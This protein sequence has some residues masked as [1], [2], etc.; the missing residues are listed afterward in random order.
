MSDQYDSFSKI[1]ED[2]WAWRRQE[3]PDRSLDEPLEPRLPD[4]GPERQEY[5]AVR[6]RE[7]DDQLEKIDR[8]RLT[9][10]QAEDF[11]VYRFQI[12]TLIGR[13]A[14]RMFERPANADSA[15]WMD[16]TSQSRR[17]LG[18]ADD[19][20]TY[21]EWLRQVPGYIDQ[22]IENMRAGVK[23]GFA[24]AQVSMIGRRRR[25]GRWRNPGPRT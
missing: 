20:G 1:A 24:P 23:R 3:I 17:R 6:W 22:N 12:K 25:S 7:V 18:S 5:R 15:F 9:P 11:D 2:E 4:V 8:S 13:Q 10:E 16:L 21:V 19:A 14:Y